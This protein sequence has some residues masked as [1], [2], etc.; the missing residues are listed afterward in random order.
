VAWFDT[1]HPTITWTQP[2]LLDVTGNLPS[3]QE[4]L[5]VMRVQNA[6]G[7]GGIHKPVSL[8]VQKEEP[9]E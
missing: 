3:G 1:V 8:M 9:M 5:L 7:A 6:S 4:P 2:F